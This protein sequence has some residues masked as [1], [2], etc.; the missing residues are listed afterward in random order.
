MHYVSKSNITVSF[1]AVHTYNYLNLNSPFVIDM[2]HVHG[3]GTVSVKWKKWWM[4][5]HGIS[6]PRRKLALCGPFHTSALTWTLDI[7]SCTGKF[8]LHLVG[9]T[10]IAKWMHTQWRFHL[11]CN[12]FRK[13][14]FLYRARLECS[15]LCTYNKFCYFGT[16]SKENSQVYLSDMSLQWTL[17]FLFE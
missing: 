14:T 6:L 3:V 7:L 9:S 2:K 17:F 10:S 5:M 4:I 13:L 12:K 15:E 11:L 1:F 8:Y 16:H